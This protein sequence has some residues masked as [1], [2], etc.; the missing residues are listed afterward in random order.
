MRTG[1]KRG[2]ERGACET[3]R[4]ARDGKNKAEINK[5]RSRLFICDGYFAFCL[6]D[7]LRVGAV[8]EVVIWYCYRKVW[9]K[10]GAPKHGRRRG[11]GSPEAREKTP[12]DENK[13]REFVYGDYFCSFL[14]RRDFD[15]AN[16][17]QKRRRE[18]RAR[19]ASK[20]EAENEA[21]INKY[22]GR[23]FI[24]GYDFAFLYRYSSD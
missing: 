2:E 5:Y 18:G 4:Q 19:H 24:L 16:R 14:F 9:T 1:G 21:E 13:L 6:C 20:R 3:H 23:L 11:G 10:R 17:R 8:G 22:R 15:F 12:R 7:I